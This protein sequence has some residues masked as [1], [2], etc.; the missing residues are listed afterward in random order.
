MAN[1]KS[2]VLL[3]SSGVQYAQF[4]VFTTM[5]FFF[6]GKTGRRPL[7]FYGAI[8]MAVCHF[9]VGGILGQYSEYVPKGVDGNLNVVI[10]VTGSPA[11]TVIAFCYLLIIIYTLTL[12]PVTW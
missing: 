6:I 2:N 3:V 5:V 10:R 8:G 11:Y 1:L 9:V 7:L 4:I 12:A